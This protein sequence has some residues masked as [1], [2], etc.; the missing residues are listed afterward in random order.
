MAGRTYSSPWPAPN[1]PALDLGD[2]RPGNG[3]GDHAVIRCL[4]LPYDGHLDL[5]G[6]TKGRFPVKASPPRR[7]MRNP[8][9][10]RAPACRWE[11]RRGRCRSVLTLPNRRYVWRT[12]SDPGHVREAGRAA[13]SAATVDLYWIP[14]G[15]G[16]HVVRISG[17]LF[18]AVLA[19]VERRSRLDLYHSALVI[20]SPEDCFVIEQAPV[21]DRYGERR[22]V[23]AQGPVG[24]RWLGRFEFSATRSGAGETGRSPTSARRS[25]ARSG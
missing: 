23:V 25:G 2:G 3:C 7:V 8:L 1:R 24:M 10:L 14:L 13:G 20:S 16:A 6:T 4:Y 18:E 17:K 11:R 21:P 19:L 22:G 12:M 15:A 5:L 9:V